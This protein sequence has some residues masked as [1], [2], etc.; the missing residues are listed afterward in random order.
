MSVLALVVA[1]SITS[2]CSKV[3]LLIQSEAAA[4]DYAC[5]SMCFKEFKTLH[6]CLAVGSA[7]AV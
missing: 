6:M 7:Y 1:R 4:A 3:V 2:V 5:R